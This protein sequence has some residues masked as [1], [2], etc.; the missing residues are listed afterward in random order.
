MCVIQ[1]V[2]DR[3]QVHLCFIRF[4][5]PAVANYKDTSAQARQELVSFAYLRKTLIKIILGNGCPIK[6][7][8]KIKNRMKDSILVTKKL[9]F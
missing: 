3:T 6:I 1:C 7:G 2:R 4:L 9:L 8:E 5:Q